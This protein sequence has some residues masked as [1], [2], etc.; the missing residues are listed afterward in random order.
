M[1]S[2]S[3]WRFSDKMQEYQMHE[4]VVKLPMVRD[5]WLWV[6][7]GILDEAVSGL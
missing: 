2:S 1:L 5:A 3:K 7:L 4:F 6:E